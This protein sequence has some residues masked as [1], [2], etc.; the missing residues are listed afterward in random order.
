MKR[1]IAVLF[2]VAFI[3]ALPLSHTFAAK[4]KKVEICHVNSANDDG[5]KGIAFGR[6]IE[7]AES[8]VPAHLDHGDSTYF[9]DLSEAARNKFEHHYGISLP[10]ADCYFHV[11][12]PV[13]VPHPGTDPESAPEG[14]EAPAPKPAP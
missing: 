4:P 8:A 6:V 9:F 10:N 2:V 12:R 11:K 5:P 3:V 7:V 14:P 13:P 1:L